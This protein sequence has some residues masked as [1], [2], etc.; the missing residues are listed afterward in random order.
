MIVVTGGTGALGR[1][2]VESLM[3]LV[4]VDQIAV[5]VRDPAK[6]S[7]LAARGIR[8]RQ[9]DF[10]DPSSLAASFEGATQVLMVSSNARASGGDAVAQHRDAIEAA[11]KARARRIVYTS[12]MGASAA[13]AFS[14]MHD[15]AATEAL[16][17]ESGISWTSLRNGFYA[18]TVPRLVGDAAETGVIEAPADGK[19]AWTAHADLAAAAANI[20]ADEGRFNGPTPPLTAAESL[21]LS[22]IAA[23]LSERAGRPVERRIVSDDEQAAKLTRLGLPPAVVEIS[24]GLYRAA[25][26]GEFARTDS[27]LATLIGRQPSTLRDVLAQSAKP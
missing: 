8:V 13:S 27:T 12:H 23:L 22:D 20:L 6:A 5:S 3:G 26:A 4:P 1:Q 24:L 15:H 9:G 21:D 16:L 14:P 25:R 2:I 10:A 11:K 17:A 19:V 18:S 7:D